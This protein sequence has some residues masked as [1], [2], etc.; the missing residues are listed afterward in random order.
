MS[1]TWCLLSCFLLMQCTI[2]DP[3]SPLDW[4]FH[5][6]S[7]SPLASVWTIYSQSTVWWESLSTR[8]LSLPISTS[9]DSSVS[10]NDLVNDNSDCRHR[11]AWSEIS[12]SWTSDLSH[13]WTR[14]G[15][16]RFA[17]CSSLYRW[18]CRCLCHSVEVSL[19]VSLLVLLHSRSMWDTLFY[20]RVNVYC[21]K[22]IQL[23]YLFSLNTVSAVL[24]DPPTKVFSRG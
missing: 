14:G 6:P 20:R 23:F 8:S 1:H 13:M 12:L 15:L 18:Y 10:P 3:S 17:S 4:P 2:D 16:K 19:S 11:F 21:F 9:M 22:S 24:T 7:S 5:W